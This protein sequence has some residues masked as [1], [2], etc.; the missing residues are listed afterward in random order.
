MRLLFAIVFQ[1]VLKPEWAD[2]S[3][4][5]GETTGCALVDGESLKG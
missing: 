2:T 4:A 3:F 5:G 1:T